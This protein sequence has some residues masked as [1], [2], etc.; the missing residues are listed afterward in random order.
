MGMFGFLTR[1]LADESWL[2][3]DRYQRRRE[4]I[5]TSDCRNS[6]LFHADVSLA[7]YVR[8]VEVRYKTLQQA[9]SEISG[10]WTVAL[11]CGTVLTM[12]ALRLS[13]LQGEIDPTTQGQIDGL[14]EHLT[15]CDFR[16]S[17]STG[18]GSPISEEI[19]S[20]SLTITDYQ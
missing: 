1:S 11:A 10:S 20:V 13:R 2:S 16:G 14:F 3:F 9:I 18:A 7:R 17:E 6:A 4:N 19:S 15:H 12:L 5:C 8:H